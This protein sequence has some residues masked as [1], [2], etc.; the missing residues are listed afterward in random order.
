[1][2]VVVEL[3]PPALAVN[4]TDEAELRERATRLSAKDLQH[5]TANREN[6]AAFWCDWL[7]ARATPWHTQRQVL[8][9]HC[10][11]RWQPWQER[12]DFQWA[13]LDPD[14]FQPVAEVSPER[15]AALT[16]V[17]RR[18]WKDAFINFH[19]GE[20]SVRAVRE[21]VAVCR[22][23]AIPVAFMVPPISP[24]FRAAFAPG[25]LTEAESYL[26][27]V[28][29]ELAVPV[30]P[31]MTDMTEDEFMDGHHMLK[32]GAERYSRWLADTHINPWL[33][34]GRP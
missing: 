21:L 17:A 11:P 31:A 27:T 34:G 6:S 26:R 7:A 15:R 30:F 14:G 1:L 29:K 10:A 16:A 22:Q 5:L 13:T 12:I 8:M 18:E 23:N 19:A 28:S 9:S 25:V 24:E 2:A 20:S 32:H 33:A 3:F 4:A